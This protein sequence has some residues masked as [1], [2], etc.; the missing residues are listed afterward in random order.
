MSI[1]I[2]QGSYF[3]GKEVAKNWLKIRVCMYFPGHS[4]WRPPKFNI[5]EIKLIRAIQDAPRS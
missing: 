2:F 3:R 1:I 4:F 5:P